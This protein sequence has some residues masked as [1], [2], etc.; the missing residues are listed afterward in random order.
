MMIALFYPAQVKRVLVLVRD[1]I[2]ETVDI[3]RARGCKIGHA[4]LDMARAHDVER[5]IEDGIV[6]GHGA[7]V[8]L[9]CAA[10][11]GLERWLDSRAAALRGSALFASH[12]RVTG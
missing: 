2:A 7:G 4:K 3:E 10:K 8:I 5:R 6:E 9:R 12:L 1:D 11:P